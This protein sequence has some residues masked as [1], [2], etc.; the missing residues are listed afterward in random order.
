M[1]ITNSASIL[2]IDTPIINRINEA[3][4]T[5]ICFLRD[6]RASCPSKC[7]LGK[8]LPIWVLRL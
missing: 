5:E 1:D 7:D 6:K 4:L 3:S 2:T 8:A